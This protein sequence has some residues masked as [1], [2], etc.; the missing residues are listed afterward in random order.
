MVEI[1]VVISNNLDLHKNP[2]NWAGIF[3]AEQWYQLSYPS[4]QATAYDLPNV[5][6]K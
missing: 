3:T 1:V 2:A 4:A 5:F 6:R